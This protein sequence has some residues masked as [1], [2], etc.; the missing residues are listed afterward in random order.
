MLVRFFDLLCEIQIKILN[1]ESQPGETSGIIINYIVKTIDDYN[2]RNKV[3]AF[4]GD[5]TNCNFGGVSRRGTNNVFYKL[6]EKVGK[7]FIGGGCAFH[8]IQ[9]AIQIAV[10]CLPINIEC[11][12]VKIYYFFIFT[13]LEWKN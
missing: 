12:I 4:C 7:Q 8:I 6:Q 11:I 3:V 10:D 1:L 2:I 5:N 13:L 9:N